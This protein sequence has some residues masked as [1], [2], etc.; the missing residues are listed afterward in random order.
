MP[1]GK[2]F[3]GFLSSYD[4]LKPNPEFE[5]TVSYVSDDP[6]K[7]IHKYVAVIIEPV[8]IYVATD[9]SA[10]TF[11][12][13]GRAALAGYFQST[14]AQAVNDAFPVIQEPGPLVLRLRS[15]LIGVDV[16]GAGQDQKGSQTLS[17]PINIGKV[18]V[19]M[20]LVD[21]VTGEQIAAA[22]DRHNLGEGAEVGSVDFSREEKFREATRAFQGWAAR[23]RAFVDSAHELSSDDIARNKENQKPY[24]RD[25][26]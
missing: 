4:K 26:K 12:D 16:G 13:N 19:E 9:A 7:N 15:A 8:A 20:E 23:L 22:V 25:E 11:P 5:N 3:S 17:R 18:G 2:Q 21:S 10:Q 1:A 14:L 24:G 6:A